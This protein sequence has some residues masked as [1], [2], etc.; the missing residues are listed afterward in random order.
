M[1]FS[2]NDLIK[3]A[4]LGGAGGG[5]GGGPSVQPDWN[6]TDETAADFIRNK[7]F[8][9]V[10]TGGDTLTW[11]F[12][13]Y[14]DIDESLMVNE[15]FYP[16]SN[17]VLTMDDYAQGGEFTMSAIGVS[18]GIT[19]DMVEEISPGITT[20]G[21]MI[22]SVTADNATWEDEGDVFTFPKAGIYTLLNFIGG[23]IT[24]TLFG[25][26]KFV[27]VKQIDEKYIPHKE[28]LVYYCDFDTPVYLYTDKALTT[29]ATKED[30][31]TALSTGNI[32]VK[33]VRN[34]MPIN[35]LYPAAVNISSDIGETAYARIIVIMDIKDGVAAA[36]TLYT[37]EYTPST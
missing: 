18:S 21:Y 31:K 27:G 16:L 19:A 3:A 35:T 29:T 36:E 1:A 6:Q 30:V 37:A 15:T 32:L 33:N 2:A 34:N 22:F 4:M 13:S 12:T 11:K 7:P 20:I 23:D 25:C 10:P 24:L 14:D 8:G 26:N 5:G 17:V 9:E 28:Q